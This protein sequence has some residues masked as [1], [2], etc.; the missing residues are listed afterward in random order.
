M[1]L[2]EE[3]FGARDGGVSDI[4]AIWST[5]YFCEKRELRIWRGRV[6][7][8]TRGQGDRKCTVFA[9]NTPVYLQK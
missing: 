9:E 5:R 7:E 8:R 3:C 4:L 6:S 1:K 2:A